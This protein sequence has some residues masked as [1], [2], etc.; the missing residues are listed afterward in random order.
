LKVSIVLPTYNESGHIVKFIKAVQAAVKSHG[1]YEI[2]LVD[3]N[4]PDKTGHIVEEAF[5]KDKHVNVIIRE[6]EKGLATAI[7]TGINKS[8]GTHILLMDSD[9][10]HDPKYLKIFFSLAPFYDVVGGT[11]YRW[12]G[13]MKGARWRY[14]GSL[15]FNLFLAFVL[16][17]KTSDNTSGF[18]LFRKSILKKMEIEKVFRGYGDMYI[19]F[20]YAAK[21]LKL[22]LAEIPVVY[23]FRASGESKTEFKKYIFVYTMEVFKTLFAGKKL[24]KK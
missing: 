22:T 4:S 23:D 7:L 13:D 5:K 19:R 10:N 8:K 11:R 9:F 21:L 17:M 24:I 16:M 15:I 12:G 2:F 6:N 3:D 14:V 1:E 20:L 18:V